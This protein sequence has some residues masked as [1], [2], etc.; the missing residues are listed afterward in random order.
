[1]KIAL[2][3]R[4]VGHVPSFKNNKR[5]ILDNGRM[6]TLTEPKTKKWMEQVTDAFASQ[7][8][9]LTQ[10]NDAVIPMAPCPPSLI[11]SSLPLDDSRQWLPEITIKCVEVEKGDEGATI[12]IEPI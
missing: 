6:R 11:V 4:N 8:F 2:V 1:M 12:I 9:S 10:T 5:A 7:L 3:V